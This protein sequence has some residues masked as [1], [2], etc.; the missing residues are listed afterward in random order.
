MRL[1]ATKN[2]DKLI[3]IFFIFFI[4][5]PI[6][7][8]IGHKNPGCLA[9]SKCI[10]QTG[11]KHLL[12]Q[13]IAKQKQR[14]RLNKAISQGLLPFDLWMLRPSTTDTMIW[15]SVCHQ[16]K[17]KEI[18]IGKLFLSS[19]KMINNFSNYKATAPFYFSDQVIRIVKGK[20][21]VYLATSFHSRRS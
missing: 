17:G 14:S 21:K 20:L 11:Q 10:M 9:N 19:G 6:R 5:L 18:F 4:A 1:K 7:G 12:W 3:T 8:G 16:H 2:I 13:Q 15:E